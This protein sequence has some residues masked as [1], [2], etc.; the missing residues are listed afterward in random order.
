[1][2]ISDL[3]LGSNALGRKLGFANGVGEAT[4]AKLS[5]VIDANGA[6]QKLSGKV[7]GQKILV[8]R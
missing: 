4:G 5:A 1:M 2:A 3:V 6:L 7:F 8:L